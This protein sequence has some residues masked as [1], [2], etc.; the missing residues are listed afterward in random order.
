MQPWTIDLHIHTLLSPCAQLEM[1]P[2]AVIDRAIA[3]GIDVIAITDHNSCGNV[4]AFVEKG[5]E[6][7]LIVVPG[8]ELQT[9]ED[10]HLLCLFDLVEQALAFEKSLE[11]Y[12]PPTIPGMKKL[13]DQWKVDKEGRFLSEETRMLLSGM[14]LSVDQAVEFVHL[15]GGICIAAHVDRPAYS[16]YAVF[17][18]LP[19]NIPFD[20]IE[21]TCHLPRNPA[22]LKQIEDLGYRYITSSDAHMLDQILPFH[23]AANLEEWSVHELSLALRGKQGRELTTQR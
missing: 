13:G 23:C 11:P 5:R 21:L 22:L 14:Q 10:I 3:Q 18:M 6:K 20:G 8:M 19:S 7:G 1:T 17:G 4:K 16:V 12:H 15:H 2:E 9:E